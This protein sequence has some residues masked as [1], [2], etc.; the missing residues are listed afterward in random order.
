[1]WQAGDYLSIDLNAAPGRMQLTGNQ[2]KYGCFSN[3]TGAHDS[4]DTATLDAHADVIKYDF[5]TALKRHVFDTD[6]RIF[7]AVVPVAGQI[8]INGM[9]FWPL[10]VRSSFIL[11]IV[12]W[13]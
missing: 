4:N 7:Q 1:M 9:S 6:D 5:V 8:K 10:N 11:L 12:V 13:I 2:S 3:T